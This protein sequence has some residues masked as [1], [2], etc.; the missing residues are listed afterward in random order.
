MLTSAQPR[1]MGP[2]GSDEK[3]TW[4]VQRANNINRVERLDGKLFRAQFGFCYPFS[5]PL[6]LAA[7]SARKLQASGIHVA[8]DEKLVIAF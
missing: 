2:A 7:S 5:K 1:P 3:A 8:M 4:L 6:A